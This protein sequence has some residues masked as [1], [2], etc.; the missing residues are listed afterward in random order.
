MIEEYLLLVGFERQVLRN[1]RLPKEENILSGQ[2][3]NISCP[4]QQDQMW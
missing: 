3:V 4:L 1:G 2:V